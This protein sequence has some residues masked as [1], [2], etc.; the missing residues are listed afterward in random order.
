MNFHRFLPAALCALGLSSI[1]ATAQ[2]TPDGSTSWTR[3]DAPGNHDASAS[4]K[5]VVVVSGEHHF[6]GNLSGKCNSVTYNGE[7]LALAI[8]ELPADPATG[9]HGQTY[10]SIWYLDDPGA[11]AGNGDIVIDFTGNSWVATA[12]GLSGTLPGAGDTGQVSGSAIIGASS[13]DYGALAIAAVGMGGQGNTA[14]PLPGVTATAPAGADTIAALKIGNNWAGHA[15]ATST[16]DIPAQQTFAFNTGKTDLASVAATF[17]AA[18]PAVPTS[19]QPVFTDIVPGSELEISWANLL[20]DTGS[21]VWVD[22]WIGDDPNNLTKEVAA[23]PDGL[24][25]TSV[26]F[27][28]PVEGT[29]YVRIDSYLDGAPSGTPVTGDV[30][31]FE[32]TDSGLRAETWIGLRSNPSLLLLQ[33]EGI[34]IRDADQDVRLEAAEITQVGSRTGVRFRGLVKPATTGYHT[35][36]IAGSD[37][38]ALWLSPDDSRFDKERVA[39]SLQSTGPRQWDQFATQASEPVELQ[40]GISYYI[41]AQVMNS[42][43]MGHIA[44]GWPPPDAQAPS[45]IPVANLSYLPFDEEDPNDNN[46]PLSWKQ[47]TGLDQIDE[48]QHPGARS[49]YGD[50]D[51]D[52][53][54]N[55]DEYILDSNPLEKEELANVLTRD[56]WTS[57]FMGSSSLSVLT[58]SPRLYDYP[59]ETIYVAGVD[60]HA[61]GGQYAAR[62]RGFIV[63]PEDGFYQFWVTGT[64]EVQ[65][66]LADGSVTPYGENEPRTDRFGKRLIAW[67]EESPTGLAW[68][69]RHDFDRTPGQRSEAIHLEEGEKYYIEVLH[70]RGSVT[71]QDHV[72]LAWQPP[73]EPRDFI[74]SEVFR[75]DMPHPEDLDDDGLPDAWQKANGLD[76]PSLTVVERGQFGDPDDDGL[77]NLLEY[78]YGTDPLDW[79][80]SNN[81]ISD[82]DEIFHY[83][84]DP[85][86]SNSLDPQ[87]IDNLPAPQQYDVDAT[88]GGWTHNADGTLSARDPRGAISYQF[89]VPAT[90]EGIHEIFITGSAIGDIRP[91]ERLPLVLSLNDGPPFANLELVSEDGSA[92]TAKALTPWLA[93]GQYT[94]TILHDND[95]AVRRL[96]IHELDIVLLGGHSSRPDAYPDWAVANAAATHTLTRVPVE[97]LTSPA[98]IEGIASSLGAVSLEVTMAAQSVNDSRPSAEPLPHHPSVNQG[99]FADVPLSPDGPVLLKADFLDELFIESESITW[100][101]TNL[102]AHDGGELHIRTGDAMR[103]DAYSGR[104]GPDGKPFTVTLDGVLMEDEDENTSHTSGE[105]FIAEFP[106]AGVFTLVASHDG[107]TS[108][109]TLHVHDADFG[110]S[111]SV[112]AL[113]PRG[114]TPPSLGPL[115]DVEH[116]DLLILHETT[117][118]PETDPRAFVTAVQQSGLRRVLARLPETIDDVPVEGAPSAILATGTVSGFRID[119]LDQ[120]SDPQVVFRYQ[121]GTWLMRST[122]FAQDVPADILIRLT[123][124]HQGTVFLNGSNI[125]DLGAGDFDAN[126]AYHVYYEWSGPGDPHL[127][128]NVT[129]F[130]DP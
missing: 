20:P 41:E 84:I 7:P 58:N 46:L 123:T 57:P 129:L 115:L 26:T 93:S 102:F 53:I 11:H 5:L 59:N 37:N 61:R 27:E 52:G 60:D 100:I 32:V 104:A 89:T 82:F 13:V 73:G 51:Q 63:A 97:S 91:V 49:E 16:I 95:R 126:G 36:H 119:N 88:T 76:D 50:P 72:S 29:Y 64:C 43:G 81:D 112:A 39:Y 94:L 106:A 87:T 34:K 18:N 31:A 1:A 8:E 45:V 122:I 114:W 113:S 40:V 128:H 42:G 70:K 54:S 65:L 103:L 12:V 44:I 33:Q 19:P 62:Y 4:D 116:D 110:P 2:V 35:F 118:D 24:N 25:L 15:V 69:E 107:Q 101:A 47:Q 105:P 79:D 55:F 77:I 75:A 66:W 38:T 67:N 125:L 30:F 74:P 130:I 17:E 21:D 23:D 22:V 78:Q 108:T 28:A 92:D 9:G 109:V 117:E 10:A 14:T 83:G 85:H 80:T 96:R 90:E 48:A 121:D 68:P 56:T 127:C 99:F 6:P 124:V 71:G 3:I 98:S 120:T 111:H 86:A